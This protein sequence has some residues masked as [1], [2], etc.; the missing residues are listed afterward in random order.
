MIGPPCQQEC[1][2]PCA[3][4][5]AWVELVSR[6]G[7]ADPGW[8][9]QTALHRMLSGTGVTSM[10]AQTGAERSWSHR[11]DLMAAKKNTTFFFKE[12]TELRQKYHEEKKQEAERKL[13]GK[14]ICDRSGTH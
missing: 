11:T 9:A 4:A 14:K 12:G 13:Y 3:S 5:A 7:A 8:A 1:S 6:D 2:P 10:M